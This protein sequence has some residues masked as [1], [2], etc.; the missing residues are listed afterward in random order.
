MFI[1]LEGI[2]GSGKSTVCDRLAAWLQAK[3]LD[4]LLTREPGSSSLGRKLRAILLDMDS[5]GL[6]EQS[7]LFLYLADRAQH[8]REVLSPALSAGKIVLCDRYADSTLAYQGYGRGV[9]LDELTL[10]NNMAIRGLWPDLTLLFDLDANVGLERA[11]KR[12]QQEAIEQSEGRF[13]A[14]ELDFHQRIRQGYLKL[15]EKYAYRYR[16]VNASLAPNQVFEQAQSH[17]ALALGIKA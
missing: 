4:L 15:A 6:S 1:T 7:E 12:N 8:V 13:E 16:L 3:G 14:E 11:R 5:V 10:V 2:E 9:D 17:I